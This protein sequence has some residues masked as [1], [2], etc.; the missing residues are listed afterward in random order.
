MFSIMQM[1]KILAF[2]GLNYKDLWSNNQ[3]SK[4]LRNTLYKEQSNAFCYFILGGILMNEYTTFLNWCFIN[5][6]SFI[7]YKPNTNNHNFIQLITALY[8]DNE[9]MDSIIVLGKLKKK[10]K[11]SHFLLNTT[12]MSCIELEVTE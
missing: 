9:L 1:N 7:K 4:G 10:S 5:N 11:N 3:I 12:R 6:T 8:K 2:M